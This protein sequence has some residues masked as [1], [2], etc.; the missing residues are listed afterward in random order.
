MCQHISWLLILHWAIFTTSNY[1]DARYSYVIILILK[2]NSYVA[3]VP[4][5]VFSNPLP[6]PFSVE[7]VILFSA[8]F[9]EIFLE[10]LSFCALAVE[11][12]QTFQD[13]AHSTSAL[14]DQRSPLM[15]FVS[16][17]G[18]EL[19]TI[20]TATPL[21]TA[22][23]LKNYFISLFF[24]QLLKLLFSWLI[25]FALLIFFSIE[26]LRCVHIY[27]IRIERVTWDCR[28]IMDKKHSWI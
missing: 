12:H 10:N 13:R 21:H 26:V 18:E 15:I 2:K 28:M 17:W 4:F 23:F 20:M 27:W 1:L 11:T 22:P 9:P 6:V 8:F 14:P 16:A 3:L 25:Q 24:G 7:Q 19:G 5:D